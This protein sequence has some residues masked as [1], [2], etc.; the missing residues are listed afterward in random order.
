MAHRATERQLSLAVGDIITHK[1]ERAKALHIY[2]S[3]HVVIRAD[4]GAG[5]HKLFE[6]HGGD[7]GGLL[8][9][10]RGTNPPNDAV[11]EEPTEV[12]AIASRISSRS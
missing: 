1:G 6:W 8:P 4:R 5:A 3:G 12:L 11:A 7:V 10:S 2:L 9:F